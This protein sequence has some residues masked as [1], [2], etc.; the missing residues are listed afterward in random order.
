[1]AMRPRETE[2]F[3]DVQL[4]FKNFTGEG[5]KYNMEGDRNFCILLGEADALH[6]LE[7]GWNVK[8]LRRQ[9]EDDEQPYQLKVAVSYKVRAPQVWLITA[10]HRTLLNET[11]VGMLDP[12][13]SSR[14]DLVISGFN[15]D[16][17][18]KSGKKAYLQSLFF[19]LYQDELELEYAHI[20]QATSLGDMESQPELEAGSL[21]EYD[22]EGEVVD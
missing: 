13:P 1:M 16:V 3:R 6:L 4:L 12:L 8:P 14:V 5:R 9:E 2:V 11:V 15:W 21:R 20:P 17:N 19:T 7:R 18:G 22:Y 10:G